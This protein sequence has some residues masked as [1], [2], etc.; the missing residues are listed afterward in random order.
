MRGITILG[1]L[2]LVGC[3]APPVE[4]RYVPVSQ[5][6]ARETTEGPTILSFKDWLTTQPWGPSR[7]PCSAIDRLKLSFAQENY[8]RYVEF[9]GYL[10]SLRAFCRRD[11]GTVDSL[12]AGEPPPD[13]PVDSGVVE[14]SGQE[15]EPDLP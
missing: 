15:P 5:R 8:D 13:R 7:E 11:S 1:V 12:I 6:A 3:Q 2:F 4:V 10:Q 14:H 9:E